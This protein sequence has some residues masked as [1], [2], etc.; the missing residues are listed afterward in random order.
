MDEHRAMLKMK[1][2]VFLGHSLM[3]KMTIKTLK[4]ERDFLFLFQVLIKSAVLGN[5]ELP[6]VQHHHQPHSNRLGDFA[7]EQY[8]NTAADEDR[9]P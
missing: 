3:K 4:V 9:T 6:V 2:A 8:P 1:Q 5:F 7:T